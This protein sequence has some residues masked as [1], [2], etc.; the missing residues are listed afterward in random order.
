[1]LCGPRDV[2]FVAGFTGFC[3]VFLR[4]VGFPAALTRML[5][6]HLLQ[7]VEVLIHEFIIAFLV[8]A[9][10]EQVAREVDFKN[11]HSFC[12]SIGSITYS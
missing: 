8:K 4:V 11:G 9:A 5:A 1:V 2:L 3:Q 12:S 10:I 7:L 6:L